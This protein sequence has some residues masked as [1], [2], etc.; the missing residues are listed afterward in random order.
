LIEE[1]EP[2][3]IIERNDVKVRLREN[4]PLEKGVLYGDAPEEIVITQDGIK[5]AVAPLGGQKTGS[6]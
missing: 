1:F 6:F 5:F 3:A 4:L 2:R